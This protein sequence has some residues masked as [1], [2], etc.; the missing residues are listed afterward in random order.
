MEQLNHQTTKRLNHQT[1][2]GRMGHMRQTGL[3]GQLGRWAA[4]G[5]VAGGMLLGSAKVAEA[6]NWGF[7]GDDR[8]WVTIEV[9]GKQSSYSLWNGGVGT[10]D[11]AVI[12]GVAQG[13]SLKIVSYDTK[14]WK[15]GG[16]VTG[17]QYWYKIDGEATGHSMGGG[18]IQNLDGNNQKW[19]NGSVNVNVA[20]VLAPG[21]HTLTI[22]GK[23]TG[24][25]DPNGDQWD[26]NDGDNYT[27]TFYVF[28][29]TTIGETSVQI[30]GAGAGYRVWV[31]KKDEITK[32]VIFPSSSPTSYT[33]WEN[34]SVTGGS[35]AVY[36]GKGRTYTSGSYQTYTLT[37]TSGSNTG[38]GL[39]VTGSGGYARRVWFYWD[40]VNNAATA[41]SGS[42]SKNTIIWGKNSAYAAGNLASTATATRGTQLANPQHALGSDEGPVDAVI[43]GNYSYIGMS[44]AVADNVVS[45][46]KV[47]I[48]WEKAG[49]DSTAA[50]WPITLSGLTSDT[51]YTWGVAN[52]TT[53]M[54]CGEF[55]TTAPAE[56][57]QAALTL[58]GQA[59][60]VT[61]TYEGVSF[62]LPVGGG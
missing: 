17:C 7:F 47:T 22:Y 27:A 53:M 51:T 2:K 55:T 26:S 8:S 52:G 31:G 43:S 16:D 60:T 37:R 3:S 46:S 56:V 34:K 41:T 1:C 24:T 25:G 44:S 13:G 14:T 19:G 6:A 30:G 32:S 61:K 11:G 54:A 50:G 58:D 5:V 36:A 33:A 12:G 49:A 35:G 21:S 28:G 62:T 23:I 42:G 38:M 48:E 39:W 29:P 45:V 10:F 9:E 57:E 18:W 15:S 20:S 40:T 59:S 4:A